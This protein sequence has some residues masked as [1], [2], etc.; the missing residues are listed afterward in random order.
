MTRLG[1]GGASWRVKNFASGEETVEDP[2]VQP[3][4]T[5]QR[6]G[7]AKRTV[8]PLLV[9]LL[10][11]HLGI[12]LYGAVWQSPVADEIPHVVS[13]L[14]H[15][16][17]A[18][19]SLYRVNPPLARMW[20]TLPIYL[21]EPNQDDW[22]KLYQ[23]PG[24]FGRTEFGA[25]AAF[26]RQEPDRYE[27]I[28]LIARCTSSLFSVLATVVCFCWAGELY[29][30]AAAWLA[31]WLWCFSPM[32]LGYAAILTPDVPSAATGVL[33]L[34]TYWRWIRSFHAGDAYIAG[35]CLGVAELTK[36]T[37]I[38][39]PPLMLLMWIPRWW[40]AKKRTPATSSNVVAADTVP[41]LN[42][43]L[44][45]LLLLVMMAWLMLMMGYSFQGAFQKLEDYQFK[46]KLLSGQPQSEQLAIGNRFLDS[47]L[48]WLPVPLPKQ[49]VLGFDYHKA[50]VQPGHK[51]AYLRGVLRNEGWWYYYLYALGVKCTLGG[52][53]LFASATLWRVFHRC[54]RVRSDRPPSG[55]SNS[56]SL[57]KSE[58]VLWLPLL[59][60]L[61]LLSYHTG[62]NKHS[63]YLLPIFPL[64]II[65]TSQCASWTGRV[66]WVAV[67]AAVVAATLSSLLAVPHSMAYFNE[68]V[69]GMRNGHLH[70]LNSNVDWG[71]SLYFL[72]DEA[73]R[74]G[75]S[76]IGLA[77]RSPP[78]GAENIG[79]DFFAP[80]LPPTMQP[81]DEPLKIL[82][83]GPYA[84]C[85][86]VL[87]GY[88]ESIPNGQGGYQG[89]PDNALRYFLEFE[90]V[91]H[92]GGSFLLYDLSA[93]DIRNSPTWHDAWVSSSV[94]ESAN[95]KL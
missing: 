53:A 4:K 24:D 3:A 92:V 94:A 12:L 72:R 91:G 26:I 61:F 73:K 62:L 56:R 83:P 13:G 71:Q 44:L 29:G 49:Y 65:W 70:L 88:H 78:I 47:G 20:A 84:I 11:C 21:F 14:S 32:V 9:L 7:N 42:R 5:D 15:W 37:W 33:A 74:R 86:N 19:F 43:I 27:R 95:K 40:T 90:P 35:I 55:L 41:P 30:R 28:L 25:A 89:V 75:W 51:Q 6:E 31:A 22:L 59:A 87:H 76:R 69:G 58:Y 81:A 80:P 18:D 93:E 36:M 38:I 77:L 82:Q 52:L 39:L 79:L 17:L 57:G 60:V 50:D 16:Q 68:T 67:R 2:Q 34:Y 23:N 64:A 46:S 66:T 8:V 10:A 54:Y 85:V 1:L 48:E 45:Q 63:R